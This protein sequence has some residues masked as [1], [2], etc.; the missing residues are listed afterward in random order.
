MLAGVADTNHK[1][2]YVVSFLICMHPQGVRS[3]H[4]VASAFISNPHA[5]KV[6]VALSYS[7]KR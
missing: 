4:T 1:R 5:C 2:G 7:V 3:L 6:Y